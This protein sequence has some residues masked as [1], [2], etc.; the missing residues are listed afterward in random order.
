MENKA[1]A[2]VVGVV[3]AILAYYLYEYLHHK[4]YRHD[5]LGTDGTQINPA[6]KSG[7]SGGNPTFMDMSGKPA[8]LPASIGVSGASASTPPGVGP[9]MPATNPANGLLPKDKNSE[10]AAV[11]P[12]SNNPN[13]NMFLKAGSQI[14]II[15]GVFKNAN[16]QER[17]DPPIGSAVQTP[18]NQSTIVSDKMRPS[19]EIGQG[20]A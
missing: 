6:Y 19:L 15:S 3:A 10:W 17:S 1:V 8:E 16:L 13:G 14:G 18:W 20:P 11:N 5:P 12:M 2:A 9:L 4:G 7:A